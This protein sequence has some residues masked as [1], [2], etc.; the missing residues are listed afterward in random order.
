MLDDL[1]AAGTAVDAG[2]NAGVGRRI[3][4]PVG[5]A[6]RL[7]IAGAADVAVPD[8]DAGR[9]EARP[10]RLASRP[11]EIVDPGQQRTRKAPLQAE[12]QLAADE[13]ADP[14]D[15]D[16]HQSE[17]RALQVATISRTVSGSDFVMPQP[18]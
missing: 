11:A 5:V 6:G 15:Q 16:S 1:A 9:F 14:G 12:R 10:R 3:D 17:M 7:Q 18:G 2:Q 13:A 4:D 8:A